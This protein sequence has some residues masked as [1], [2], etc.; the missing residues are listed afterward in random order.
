MI[1]FLSQI[2]TTL[3]PIYLPIE[4]TTVR[5]TVGVA[6]SGLICT[7]L[8]NLWSFS[9]NKFGFFKRFYTKNYVKISADNPIYDGLLY[10][11]SKNYCN[12]VV[13]YDMKLDMDIP[14]YIIRE[15]NK[16]AI[17]EK[18]N[19]KGNIYKIYIGFHN[20]SDSD[21]NIVNTDIVISGKCST[22]IIKEYIGHIS[23]LLN[24]EP[25]LFGGKETSSIMIY[26]TISIPLGK[27]KFTVNWKNYKTITNKNLGNTIVSA[28][29]K[30]NF[31]DDL[32]KF[33][34]SENY[35]R[36]KGIPYKRGYLLYGEPGC[37]K[38]SLMKAI[39]NKYH[40]PIFIIDL[41]A[42]KSN[43]DLIKMNN[44]INNYVKQGTLHLVVYDD[45]DRAKL[46]SKKY[47]R[48]NDTYYYTDGNKPKITEDCFL[49]VLDGL[50]E[51]YGRIT[52]LTTNYIDKI[53]SIKSLLRPGRIDRQ[54]YV[55]FCEHNQITGII[56]LHLG[57]IPE[58]VEELNENIVIT[59]AQLTHLI[60]VFKNIK[61]VIKVL[62][63]TVDFEEID[64]EK[65]CNKLLKIYKEKEEE[66]RLLDKEDKEDKE[67]KDGLDDPDEEKLDICGDD[68]KIK[69]RHSKRQKRYMRGKI[70]KQ[71]D[72]LK[73]KEKELEHIT[74]NE[75]K[76]NL[77]K[78]KLLHQKN[79][80]DLQLIR[81]E[82]QKMENI[83]DIN[84]LDIFNKDYATLNKYTRKQTIPYYRRNKNSAAII[85]ICDKSLKYT[86]L[87]KD[88][89]LIHDENKDEKRSPEEQIEIDDDQDDVQIKKELGEN[90]A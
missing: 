41:S 59:P 5:I 43:S 55:T 6:I 42:M 80:I 75:H 26:N 52:I 39:A 15:I 85:D 23:E 21:T 61:K 77:A 24:N 56:E 14:K 66:Q 31:I 22:N 49:N 62:N 69:T 72:K 74:S 67:D 30:D 7:I 47:D 87:I 44:A 17:E 71:Y 86:Q 36:K 25:M 57:K 33:A 16:N 88:K 13:G 46:F 19:H 79:M 40:M 12:N 65:M 63:T 20:V 45:I 18:F 38:T 2:I 89:L 10:Y 3:L 78:D 34:N 82:I 11:I 32:E 51:N 58:G 28:D 83:N 53:K 48:Y 76:N 64:M 27:K 9:K 81:L 50:T 60:L 68:V 73:I 29:V 54:I 4:D 8:D 84:E 37:G 1:S 90:I 35:Y 70:D